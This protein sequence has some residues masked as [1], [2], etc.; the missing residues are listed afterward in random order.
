MWYFDATCLIL[1]R[2]FPELILPEFLHYFT[3]NQM[4]IKILKFIQDFPQIKSRHLVYELLLYWINK[5]AVK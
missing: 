4:K 1:L 3:C 5:E 2:H